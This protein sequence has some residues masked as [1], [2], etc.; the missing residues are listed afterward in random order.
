[1][2]NYEDA[3]IKFKNSHKELQDA[4]DELEAYWLQAKQIILN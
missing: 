2:I 1:M 4:Q 3:Q